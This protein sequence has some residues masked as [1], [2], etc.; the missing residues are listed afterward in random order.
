MRDERHFSPTGDNGGAGIASLAMYSGPAEIA[1]AN[2]ALWHFLRDGLRQEGISPVPG[3]LDDQL[4]Y[5]RAW[6]HPALVFAQTCGYPYLHRLRNHVR[7]VATPCYAYPGCDGPNSCSFIVVRV[8][9]T[10]CSLDEFYGATAAINGRDSNS[11]MNLFRRAVAPFARNG[12]F[13]SAVVETGSHIASVD[14]V[15][16]G[17]ADVAAIDCVTYGNFLRFDPDRLAN[18]RILAATPSGPGLPFIARKT[19][20]DGDVEVLRHVLRA[21]LADPMMGEVRDTLSLCDVVEL[22]D[23]DYDQLLVLE[24]EALTMGYPTLA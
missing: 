3:G 22:S 20:P 12:R 16:A 17:V 10:A 13:F 24:R 19:M 18:V 7:L 14:A 1:A 8:D 5:D 9:S 23:D 6:L 21:A 11:G 4:A 2:E 15:T